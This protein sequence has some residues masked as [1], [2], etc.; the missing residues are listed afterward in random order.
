MAITATKYKTWADVPKDRPI[1]IGVSGS[2]TTTHLFLEPP[3]IFNIDFAFT[4]SSSLTDTITSFF[5]NLGTNILTSQVAGSIF[6][7][8]QID[9]K[10]TP[11]KIY[12]VNSDMNQFKFN[13]VY[14]LGTSNTKRYLSRWYH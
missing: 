8:S 3:Q 4:N 14:R 2:G 7:T 9:P 12:K 5:K 10:S 1:T 6:G 11:A 13:I